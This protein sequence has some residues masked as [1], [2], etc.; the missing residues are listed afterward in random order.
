MFS[1]AYGL[2]NSVDL[3]DHIESVKIDYNADMLEITAMGM[4]EHRFLSGLK[5]WSIEV[6]FFQDYAS[7]SVDATLHALVGAAAWAFEFRPSTAAVGVTNPKWT[8]SSVLEGHQPLSGS[9]GIIQKVTSKL[10][11]ATALTR[12]TA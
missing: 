10:R 11:A 2:L 7:G 4:T 9:V 12:A 1:A 5:D 8:G 6:V 3:S